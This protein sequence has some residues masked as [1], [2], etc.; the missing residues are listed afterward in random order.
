MGV[1][2]PPMIHRGVDGIASASLWYV[3]IHFKPVNFVGLC[4]ILQ[5]S[6]IYYLYTLPQAARVMESL[7]SQGYKRM[8][9]ALLWLTQH[10][11]LA[12]C[13]QVVMAMEHEARLRWRDCCRYGTKGRYGLA[14]KARPGTK[15]PRQTLRRP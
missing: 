10:E 12:D 11:G 3:A 15:P 13:L 4:R 7:S 6:E 5:A 14:L 2:K 9:R 1:L 8:S